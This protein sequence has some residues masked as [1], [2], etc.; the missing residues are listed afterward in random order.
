MN[1]IIRQLPD[2]VKNYIIPF[3]YSPQPNILLED[4]R[5]FISTKQDVS[6]TYFRHW[7]DSTEDDAEKCW[8]INDLFAFANDYE[9]T[10]FGYVDSFYN[11]FSRNIMLKNDKEK[12]KQFIVTLESESLD[13]QINI[14]WGLLTLEERND[15]IDIANMKIRI[16]N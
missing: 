4:I 3:T 12:I 11:I 14:F 5:S 6:Y 9:P 2:D 1:N 15:F 16:I 13:K 10:I 7:F 8:L